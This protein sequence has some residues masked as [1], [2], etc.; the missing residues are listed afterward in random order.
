MDRNSIPLSIVPGN[1][2]SVARCPASRF[3]LCLLGLTLGSGNAA[4]SARSES[5]VIDPAFASSGVNTP[6]VISD[7]G[8]PFVATA[9]TSGEFVAVSV[10]ASDAEDGP[11]PVTCD[12]DLSGLFRFPDCVSPN[13]LQQLV[14]RQQPPRVRGQRHQHVERLR[15]QRNRPAVLEQQALLGDEHH[16]TKLQPIRRPHMH[17]GNDRPETVRTQDRASIVVCLDGI[18]DHD[19]RKPAS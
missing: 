1:L 13:R 4:P 19:R 16:V 12:R 6:P 2:S 18:G 7:P 9:T 11:L 3:L 14:F 5:I 8:N 15:R 10:T 17:G